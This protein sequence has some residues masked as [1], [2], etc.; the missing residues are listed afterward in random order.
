MAMLK[1]LFP[2]G[3]ASAVFC[4]SAIAASADASARRDSVLLEIDGTKITLGEFEQK[5]N[6]LIQARNNFY[7]AEKKAADAFI[8]EYLLERQAKQEH[9]TVPELLEKHVNSQIPKEPSEEALRMFYEAMD[10]KQPY[11]KIRQ[12]MID[13]LRQ[14]RIDKAK[15]AYLKMLRDEAKIAV[16]LEA[17]RAPVVL[18]DTPVRGSLSAP[19][20]VV[21]YADFECPYCQQEQSALSKVEEEY[22]G[23]VAFAYKD[24]PLPMHTHA[25]KAAEAAHC[26]GAQGKYWEF[27]DALYQKKQLEVAQLKETARELKLDGD[28]FDKCLDSGETA[29]LVKAQLGEAQDYKMQG[30]PTFFINGRLYEGVLSY[31][32]LHAAIDEEL[33]AASPASAD[34]ARR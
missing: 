6:A 11:E 16:L 19:V 17:P 4:V 8:D 31:D 18:K 20:T 2:L 13:H 22:K 7:E 23:K 9:M 29:G 1:T 10:T 30:T 15:V 24:M 5:S 32:Q 12:Q 33:H 25:E 21:E 3:L 34:T 26:A 14:I 28:A 27:H